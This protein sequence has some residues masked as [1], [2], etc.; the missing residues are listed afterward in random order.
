MG[1][2]P[3]YEWTRYALSDYPEDDRHYSGAG[4]VIDLDHLMIYGKE[5]SDCPFACLYFGE[6][7]PVEGVVPTAFEAVEK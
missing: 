2:A 6:G 4:Q 7:L 5:G 3:T 1:S